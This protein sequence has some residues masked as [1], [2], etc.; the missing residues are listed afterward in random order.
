VKIIDFNYINEKDKSLTYKFLNSKTTKK[1][2]L[3]INALGKSVL[4][5]L[6]VDGIIDDFTR[7]QN[8]K[9][10]GIFQI[11]DISKDSIILSVATGSPIEVSN[12]LDDMGY[13]HLNY[14]SFLRYSNLDLK[15]PP[16]IM[17]F[18]DDF[19]N[20]KDLY[21]ETYDLLEDDLSK[22]I[23]T[24]VINF[25]ISFDISFMRDFTNDHEGQYF[26][27]DILPSMKNIV[28]VDGGGYIGDTLPY[29]IKNYC[30]YKKI[31][32]I[33]PNELHI[34]IAKKNFKDTR[35]INF[36]NCGLGKEKIVQKEIQNIHNDCRHD[37]Q[38]LNINTLDNLINEHIDFLK[39]DIE[40]AEQ[41]T[42]YGA[43]QSIMNYHPVLAICIYHKAEDWYKVPQIVL[44]F[45]NDYKI[46]LRHYM[47]GIY[48]TVMYFIPI[49]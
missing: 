9:K 44:S 17:D 30:D 41:D 11:Q 4:K 12:K 40:G 47:E 19:S 2:I 18:K 6:E 5:H 43:K 29:I 7:V 14:L 38:A 1:Y 49:K 8:S 31:Y 42:L 46:Y 24:K 20:N 3:G 22:E 27:K 34:N 45:R 23:F 15:D 26:D 33:E 16:F 37:Y 36:I 13:T 28:F 21:K 10:K 32:L 25:K 35:D 48:E 39:L